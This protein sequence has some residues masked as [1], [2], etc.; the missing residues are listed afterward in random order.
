MQE[1]GRS[2]IATPLCDGDAMQ[3]RRQASCEGAPPSAPE[4]WRTAIAWRSKCSR[5]WCEGGRRIARH[6][7]ARPTALTASATFLANGRSPWHS[8]E[9]PSSSET[10]A[11]QSSYRRPRHL[12][13]GREL[14]AARPDN[15]LASAIRGRSICFPP[16]LRIPHLSH[17]FQ[18]LRALHRAAH[19]TVT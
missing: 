3:V 17:S 19:T 9:A 16:A 7:R 15:T 5:V 12:P 8:T 4:R 11:Q 18:N 10:H 6:R 1:N 14:R 2:L 13:L